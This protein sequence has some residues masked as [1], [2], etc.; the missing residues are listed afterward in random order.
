M[1]KGYTVPLSPRG[2]ANLASAPPWHYAGDIVA[3]E[4]W[5][6]PAA[7]EATLP[8]G[9]SPDPDSSGHAVALFVD[10]QFSGEN[11]EYLDPVR[12]QY[13]EFFVLVD[14]RW[15]DQPVS[16]CPY[17]YVD[18][19]L[20]LARGWVQGFPKK[21]GSVQQTRVFAAP[22]RASPVLAAGGRFGA[23][24]SAHGR[25]LA[26][27][28]VTLEEPVSDPAALTGRPTVNL[29][30]FPRL[31]A[32]QYDKPAV[33]E[34]VMMVSSGQQVAD[35]WAGTGEIELFPARG[36]E[37]ADLAPVRTGAGFRASMAYTVTEVRE[38][39]A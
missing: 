1:V 33:H 34:L 22:G 14:A 21:L 31:A 2:D 3:V 26:E 19:D 36:E 17:I 25:S 12:S 13:R 35:V 32:G 38:L 29:R 6:D 18:N 8:D 28:R 16:W 11:E 5:T 15:K 7:A 20:A 9:L 23:T 27:A 4:F 30:H 24:V 10:W 39:T 37:L